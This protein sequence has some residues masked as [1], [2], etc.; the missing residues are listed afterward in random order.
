IAAVEPRITCL[1]HTS[2]AGHQIATM[3]WILAK[4]GCR[5]ADPYHRLSSIALYTR[6]AGFDEEALCKTLWSFAVAQVRC[7]RLATEIVHELAEL[8]ISTSSIALAI[9]SVAKLKMYHLVEDAF[10]AFRDRIVNEIDG[11]SGGDLKRLRWA[12]ASAGITDGTL[13]ET[14]FSRSFQLCQQRDVESLASLMRGLSITGQCIS[15]LSKSASSI[16]ESGMEKCK[17]N[18]IAAMAWSLS[19]ALQ[20]D[21]KFFDHVINFI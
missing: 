13:C 17:D 20:G 21:H 18:D 14:I 2:V 19:V 16:L 3:T 10:N 12:F 5:H 9:W 1:S 6:L 15:L 8:P 11:F 7:T 4:Q